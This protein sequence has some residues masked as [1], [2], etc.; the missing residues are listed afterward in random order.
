MIRIREI[1]HLVLRVGDLD[2]MLAFYC[3][4]L[5]C[6]IERRRDD[7]GLVQLR[8]GRSMIDL[9]PVG[10]RLGSAGGAAPGKEGRNLDHFC[11]RLEPFDQDAIRNVL[12]AHGI[13]AG[14]VAKRIGAEG[15]GP[16]IYVTDPEGNVVELKGPPDSATAGDAKA[17]ASGNSEAAKVALRE[18]TADTVRGVIALSVADNQKGFVAPNAVSLSQ[19]L[20]APDAWYR[21]IYSGDEL[22]GFVML[23]DQSLRT[24]PPAEPEIAVWRLMIDARFQGRGIGRAALLQV[25]EHAKHKGLFKTLQL[26]FVPGPG[27]PEPF[28]LGL[29]FRHTGRMDGIENVMELPLV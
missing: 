22:A 8:A 4:V 9:V 21:A 23:E 10:G 26:S 24:P 25:I 2:R 13:Q 27:C 29:G 28:Y 7:L 19:A 1:D 15:E 3:G 16:S 12:A 6:S 5:G 18:I 20:F 14:E 17:T 11:L